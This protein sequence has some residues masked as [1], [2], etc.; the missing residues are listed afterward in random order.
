MNSQSLEIHVQLQYKHINSLNCYIL[1]KK[2]L[3]LLLGASV[4]VNSWAFG[5]VF[6]P[7]YF[8]KWIAHVRIFKTMDAKIVGN[9]TGLYM[10]WIHVSAQSDQGFRLL[11]DMCSCRCIQ[12]LVSP[13]HRPLAQHCWHPSLSCYARGDQCNWTRWTQVSP[14]TLHNCAR[15]FICKIVLKKPIRCLTWLGKRMTSMP[16]KA[17]YITCS[18]IDML[19]HACIYALQ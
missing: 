6:L 2:K 19:A 15:L 4:D 7:S 8:L 10:V 3:R 5:I 18:C 11:Q 9:F 16:N 12:M 14:L 13:T 1:T 17:Y